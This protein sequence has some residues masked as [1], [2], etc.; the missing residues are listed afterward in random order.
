MRFVAIILL[1]CASAAQAVEVR[2]DPWRLWQGLEGASSDGDVFFDIA[3]DVPQEERMIGPQYSYFAGDAA[4]FHALGVHYQNMQEYTGGFYWGLSA[5]WLQV[6]PTG[7]TA[8]VD[9]CRPAL[10]VNA[11]ARWGYRWQVNPV[12]NAQLGIQVAAGQM[13]GR[14]GEQCAKN[15]SEL[16]LGGVQNFVDPRLDFKFSFRL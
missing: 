12:F 5:S 4:A 1:C 9:A 14:Q 15:G 11:G 7:D 8:L 10:P 2:F 13:T 16:D 3:I 6:V